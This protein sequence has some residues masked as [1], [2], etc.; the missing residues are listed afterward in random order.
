MFYFINLIYFQYNSTQSFTNTI[1]PELTKLVCDE[2]SLV[3]IACLQTLVDYL[4]V[5]N[6]D[7]NNNVKQILIEKIQVLIDFGFKL[8]DELFIVNISKNIGKIFQ[9]IDSSFIE[10]RNYFVG[11]FQNLCQDNY[12]LARRVR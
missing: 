4:L 11:I 6:D 3:K 10:K 7:T 1:L 9:S 8:K 5:I 2:I 12:F